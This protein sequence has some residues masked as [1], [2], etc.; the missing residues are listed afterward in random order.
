MGFFFACK[1][2][3]PTAPE[4]PAEGQ[5]TGNAYSFNL[6]AEPHIIPV[7]TNSVSHVTS[8]LKDQIGNGSSGST[9]LF[10]LYFNGS[11][12]IFSPY[13]AHLVDYHLPSRRAMFGHLTEQT[14]VTDGGGYARTIYL[15]PSDP[16]HSL[17]TSSAYGYGSHANVPTGASRYM[18]VRGT[19]SVGTDIRQI[20]LIDWFPI[21]L[22]WPY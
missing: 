7:G 1:A 22:Y 14:G 17:F 10:Q 16:Y 18:V 13:Y 5:Y 15:G 6:W 11:S 20:T 9:V 19:V 8:Q 3:N 12:N 4:E 2:N 21:M